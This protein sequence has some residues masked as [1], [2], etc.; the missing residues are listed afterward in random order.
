MNDEVTEC[1]SVGLKQI[2]LSPKRVR[3]QKNFRTKS[4]FEVLKSSPLKNTDSDS[5]TSR[6]NKKFNKSKHDE[7][8][9]GNTHM[10]VY[11]QCF[12]KCFKKCAFF[13]SL[14]ERYAIHL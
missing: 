11:I 1:F 14:I 9:Y 2:N 4:I 10:P 7:F 13:V 5:C 8:S 3:N 6:L 12:R